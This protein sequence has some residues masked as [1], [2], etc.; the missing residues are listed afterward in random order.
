MYMEHDIQVIVGLSGYIR[1]CSAVFDV[2]RLTY[3]AS[4]STVVLNLGYT[5]KLWQCIM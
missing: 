1:S 5:I 3:E 4:Q 2:A